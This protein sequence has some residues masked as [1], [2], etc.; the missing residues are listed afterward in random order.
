MKHSHP[1]SQL[2]CGS[3]SVIHHFLTLLLCHFLFFTLH[4]L[5]LSLYIICCVR[6][7][8]LLVSSFTRRVSV[9][10]SSSRS[11]VICPCVSIL[12][13]WPLDI[14]LSLLLSFSLPISLVFSPQSLLSLW[15]TS[16]I[17]Y[18]KCLEVVLSVCIYSLCLC[19]SP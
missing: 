12:I 16:G 17:S 4:L 14:S 5:L 3:S 19:P 8:L 10:T 7:L 2:L 6:A 9:T 18:K 13:T 15:C 11:C 1:L